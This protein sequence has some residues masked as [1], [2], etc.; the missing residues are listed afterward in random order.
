[1]SLGH[2]HGF[3]LIGFAG[4]MDALN[5]SLSLSLYIHSASNG[6]W[7]RICSIIQDS[8]QMAN[9]RAE[10]AFWSLCHTNIC[11]GEE[12][13]LH[14]AHTALSLQEQR[15]MRMNLATGASSKSA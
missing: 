5:L 7:G 6:L 14:Y 13:E 8:I 12:K 3:V 10:T 15:P 2:E 4:P 1:M 9:M 11:M